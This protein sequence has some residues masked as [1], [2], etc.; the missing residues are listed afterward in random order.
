MAYLPLTVSSLSWLVMAA[1]NVTY[2]ASVSDALRATPGVEPGTTEGDDVL[3]PSLGGTITAPALR[4]AL[5]YDPQLVFGQTAVTPSLPLGEFLS[6]GSPQVLERARMA[7]DLGR[8]DGRL[9]ATALEDF[10]YGQPD[11]LT[12]TTGPTPTSLVLAPVPQFASILYVYSN[13][14]LQLSQWFTRQLQGTALAGYVESGGVDAPSKAIIPLQMGPLATASLA[15]STSRVDTFT[16]ALTGSEADF[17]NGVRIY[18]LEATETWKRQVTRSDTVS[19]ALGAAG[20]QIRLEPNLPYADEPYP[21]ARASYTRSIVKQR[22]RKLELKLSAESAPYIDPLNG[23]DYERAE[24]MAS[25]S[26]ML[27]RTW[28]FS[29]DD[30]AAAALWGKGASTAPPLLLT[31]LSVLG[32]FGPYVA[33]EAT[34]RSFLQAGLAGQGASLQWIA[35]V[36]LILKDHGPAKELPRKLEKVKDAF[37]Q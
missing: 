21:I 35:F 22:Q 8:T 10:Q 4:L 12:L 1:G 27:N 29:T 34:A 6:N 11:L 7:L 13:S 19:W 26:L 23:L 9:H 37:S 15:Y 5:T 24:A 2:E 28:T 25:L 20:T 30:G 3:V 32:A 31:G 14:S 36:S 33:L 18:L 16:S 17:S